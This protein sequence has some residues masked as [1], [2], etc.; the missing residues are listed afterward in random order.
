MNLFKDYY[1]YIIK[2]DF[3]NKFKIKLNKKIPKIKKIILSFG[4]ENFSIQKLSSTVLALNVLAQ[5]KSSISPS[6]TPN[7]LLKIQ[8]GQPA[9]CKVTLQKN[10]IYLFINKLNLEILP[11][12]KNFLGFK[13]K[14]QRFNFFLRLHGNKIQLQEFEKS[15]PLFSNLPTLNINIVTNTN[16]EQKILFLAKSFKIPVAKKN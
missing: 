5:K 6:K 16:N 11:K 7:I 1:K 10:E 13:I 15:Y 12:L 2:K 8:K 4:C 3:I 14:K 9:G